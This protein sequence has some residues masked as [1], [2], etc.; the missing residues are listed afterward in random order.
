MYIKL[1]DKACPITNLI[2]EKCHA[3]SVAFGINQHDSC[4][5][6]QTLT[7][8]N[9]LWHHQVGMFIDTCPYSDKNEKY[10]YI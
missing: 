3:W 10:L 5:K 1:G 2:C 6:S 9:K 7:W 8:F 4:S